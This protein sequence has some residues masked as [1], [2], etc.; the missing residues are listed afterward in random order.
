MKKD[1]IG[2]TSSAVRSSREKHGDNSLIKEKTKGFF[3]RFFENLNDP[4]I[5]VLIFALIIEVVFTLGNCNFF[6]VFG[7]IAAILIA[8][9]VSTVSEYGSERAFQKMQS[10]SQISKA[11]VLRDG[12]LCE[13]DISD[14]VV[15]DIVYLYAGEKIPADGFIISGSLK[16]DQSALNGE[17]R[18][19]TKST[20]SGGELELCN[21]RAVFRG[22]VIISG[23]AVMQVKKVGVGTYYGMVARDVQSETRQ[24]PLKLRLSHFA[25]QISKIGYIMA[26]I[27]ALTYLFN[28]LVADNGFIWSKILASLKNVPFLFSTLI[29]ALTLMITVV[30]VA[31]PEGLPMMIT[32]VLSANMK[33]ML[34]DGVLVKKLVG[35]ETA[36]SMN[37]LF[38][39]KTGTLTTGRLECDSIITAD[40]TYK[41]LASLKKKQTLYDCMLMS[42]RLNTDAVVSH[43]RV[44]GGNGTDRALAEF[45][46]NENEPKAIINKKLAFSSERKYSAITLSDGRTLI[47]GAPELLLSKCTAMM[48]SDGNIIRYSRDKLEGEYVKA[49]EAGNRVIAVALKLPTKSDT[50]FVALVVLKD[51]IR[52]GVRESVAGVK[53]AG[54]QVVMLTG[55]GRETAAAIA[56]EC[57][58]MNGS[59]TDIVI[60]S[61]ELS[62]MSDDEVK[63]ILP[64]LCVLAR[65]LPQD[66]TRLVRLSQELD[67]VVGMT[68]DGI[69]DAPSLKLADVG[70]AMGNG[71]DIAKGAGDV[72]LVDNSFFSINRTILYGRTIFK[73]IRK[74][75]TFQL[76]MNLTACGVSLVGQFMGVDSPITIIQMLWVNIIMDTLGGLA[77]AGEPPLEYYMKEKPKRRSEPILSREMLHQIAITGAYTLC[78][79]IAFLRMDF[80]RGMFGDINNETYFMTAFYALFIF[81]GIFNCFGARCERMWI[82][83]NIRKNKPFVFIMIFISVIQ[84]LMIYYGGSIFRTVP[85]TAGSL[86]CVILLAA[87]VV[88]FEMIRRIFYKLRRR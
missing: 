45:F 32:V 56:K 14:I 16:V 19:V 30:V 65:A 77:F 39:D 44:V 2:L 33:K 81:A 67:L 22:S 60:T 43:G 86:L 4:I 74:F 6:E 53:R 64:H 49:A 11:R 31:A 34:K 37:I 20:S 82:L 1:I 71:A 66:K 5:K 3:R 36:G 42:A 69:N 51:K 78:M 59:S 18:D 21:K 10:E 61:S 57:G 46:K 48:D 87:S 85:L 52:R 62:K 41:S 84:I 75:I 35:I 8:T 54:V 80:F 76:I 79:C 28:T 55:D 83:S 40:A 25:S 88:P 38:T 23:E 68:G 24:S 13:I 17:S 50:V 15:G 70:F 7:I 58:I 9:T 12:E 73:S 26:G 72:I 27:V 29:H 63:R 47:K